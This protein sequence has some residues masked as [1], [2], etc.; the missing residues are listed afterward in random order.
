MT[1]LWVITGICLTNMLLLIAIA[2]SLAKL[3][4]YMQDESTAPVGGSREETQQGLVDLQQGPFFR[5][6]NGELVQIGGPT[7]DQ[8][9]FSGQRDPFADGL[10]DRPSS[11]NWDGVPLQKEE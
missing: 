3:V 10:V 7:Y 6:E 4:K 8:N 1:I 5:M 2:G 11:K 9:I